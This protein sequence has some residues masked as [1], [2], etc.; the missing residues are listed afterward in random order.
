MKKLTLA[1]MLLSAPAFS[2]NQCLTYYLEQELSE[3]DVILDDMLDNVIEDEN[4]IPYFFFM[5]GRN[6]A[7]YEM[8]MQ[9]DEPCMREFDEK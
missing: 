6:C 7:L 4:D 5:L 1:L 2:C 9:I 8:R 3:S